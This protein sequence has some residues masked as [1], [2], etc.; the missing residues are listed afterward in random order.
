MLLPI[1]DYKSFTF[2]LLG[3]S[4]RREILNDLT[5]N[6]RNY[7]LELKFNLTD[8]LYSFGVLKVVNKELI[9]ISIKLINE[10]NDLVLFDAFNYLISIKQYVIPGHHLFNDE[11]LQF[12]A[13]K[14]LCLHLK[15]ESTFY[16]N[17]IY[18]LESKS[19]SDALISTEKFSERILTI[20]MQ[21]LDL[22]SSELLLILIKESKDNEWLSRSLF[23]YLN[24]LFRDFN[25]FSDMQ[26]LNYLFDIYM[27]LSLKY[28]FYNNEMV[29][30]IIRNE[31]TEAYHLLFYYLSVFINQADKK[32]IMTILSTDIFY[33]DPQFKM[34]LVCLLI[35]SFRNNLI[36]KNQLENINNSLNNVILAS[37]CKLGRIRGESIEIDYLVYD[38]LGKELID[39]YLVKKYIRCIVYKMRNE[40]V[41]ESIINLI[42]EKNRKG[43][44]SVF[45]LH[46]ITDYFKF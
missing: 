1:N 3:N 12:I 25:V 7:L 8:Y 35:S 38:R 41:D 22:F 42:V 29:N 36:N 21:N 13:I 2:S 27:I 19:L 10:S 4:D 9:D 23:E 34:S 6:M 32:I 26:T 39:N 28:N 45:T 46:S 5:L 18:K 33:K 20:N 37:K 24:K 11:K 31:I 15:K 30:N 43:L 17:K 44:E 14:M 40:G 16:Y